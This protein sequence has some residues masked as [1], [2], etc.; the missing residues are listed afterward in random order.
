MVISLSRL[1]RV[2]AVTEG[3]DNLGA[4]KGIAK[5]EDFVKGWR[6]TDPG[7][8]FPWINFQT[9]FDMLAAAINKAG[10]LDPMQIALA[11]EGM[12]M[13]DLLGHENVMRADD[14][15]LI[16]PFYVSQLVRN[17][18]YDSEKTGL[19]WR[20]QARIDAADLMQPHTCKMQRPK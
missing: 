5:A 7:F 14:H 8:D 13:K 19:G 4:E 17:V 11:L 2:I 3:H 10:S 12:K 15:Q 1:N 6:A 20:T 18:K 16:E 9:M